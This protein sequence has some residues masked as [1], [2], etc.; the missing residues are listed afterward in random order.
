MTAAMSDAPSTV[1]VLIAVLAVLAVVLWPDDAPL[2]GRGRRRSTAPGGVATDP[3]GGDTVADAAGALDLT[4]LAVRSG[5]GPTEA[6]EEAARRVGGRAGHDLAV[7]AAAHRWGQPADLAWAQVC[8]VWRPA[9]L[10]W[11][12]AD[13]SGSAPAALIAAAAQRVRASEDTRVEASVQRAA[14]RLVLPL[15]L[16]FLPGFV[17]TT[18]API[19]L[20]LARS[21]AGGGG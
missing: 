19:V 2:K 7:V 18:V 8:D 1:P 9:S 20:H 6:L 3:A 13:R 21:V 17:C 12:A 5:L 14:V 16:C 4:A 10:A 15:G 11:R